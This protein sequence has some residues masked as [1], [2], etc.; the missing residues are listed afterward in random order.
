[1]RTPLALGVA[2]TSLLLGG[3]AGDPGCGG[4]KTAKQL[5]QDTG[6]TWDSSTC[7]PP[8]WPPACGQPTGQPCGVVCGGQPVCVC[9]ASAP[10]WQDGQGCLAPGQCPSPPACAG[11]GSS[12]E[13]KVSDLVAQQ[14][15]KA[16][17]APLGCD[18]VAFKVARQHSQAMCDAGFFSHVAPDGST[19]WSRLVAGG[20]SF[21]ACGENIAGGQ[22]TPEAVMQAW[23]Q[24]ASHKS[25]ILGPTFT[26]LG[27]GHAS[28]AGG[29]KHY[30]TQDFL[31]RP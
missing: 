20:A 19:P 13:V 22:T 15:A 9:P 21:T 23:M 8:C 3:T 24:S 5:C 7:H 11:Y 18:P 31:A 25:Q 27:V 26:H 12:F 29:L 30:W 28:C 6:G 1:V 17:L 10:H 4:V 2:I 16:G 14:R